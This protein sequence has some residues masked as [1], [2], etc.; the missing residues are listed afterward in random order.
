MQKLLL[1][2]TFTFQIVLCGKTDQT[3]ESCLAQGMLFKEEKI[4][5]MMA[6]VLEE[7]LS[8]MI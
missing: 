6:V 8:G 3:Y 7:M 1:L 2:I 4:V 5:A